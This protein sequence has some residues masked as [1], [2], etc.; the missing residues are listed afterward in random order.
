MI[1]A[2]FRRLD[3][4]GRI[5]VSLP[6][7]DPHKHV[8]HLME[9]SHER[10]PPPKIKSFGGD[11]RKLGRSAES[12]PQKLPSSAAGTKGGSGLLQLEGTDRRDADCRSVL[13]LCLGRSQ[14]VSCRVSSFP[15]LTAGNVVPQ[16]RRRLEKPLS[17]A[18]RR[19]GR[20]KVQ[21]RQRSLQPL[22]QPCHRVHGIRRAPSPPHHTAG[23]VRGRVRRRLRQRRRDPSE[24][25][26]VAGLPRCHTGA[27]G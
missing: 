7:Q 19:Q 3:R 11:A 23:G 27:G 12:G 4:V 18:S 22:L 25:L 16:Q 17:G 14:T 9:F 1:A 20:H 26:A 2:L 6:T 10:P 24:L 21:M 15:P 5:S 13:L 8:Q